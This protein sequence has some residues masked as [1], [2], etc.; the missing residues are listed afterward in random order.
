MPSQVTLLE[1]RSWK[2]CLKCGARMFTTNSVRVCAGCHRRN[3]HLLDRLVRVA[4]S[5]CALERMICN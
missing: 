3:D 4:C 5:P 2:R 1:P